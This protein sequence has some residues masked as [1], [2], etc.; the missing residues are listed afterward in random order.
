MNKVL[1]VVTH[2]G[3]FL[4]GEKTGLYL[5]ELIDVVRALEAVDCPFVFSTTT[6]GVPPIDGFDPDDE[7]HKKFFVDHGGELQKAVVLAEIDSTNFTAV[8]LIGGHGALYDFLGNPDITKTV[9]AIYAAGGLI[10]AT[11]H[12]VAGLVEASDGERL[13][14]EGKNVTTF[15]TMEEG[16]IDVAP[17]LPYSLTNILETIGAKTSYSAQAFES[18]VVVDGRV[19]TAQ[20]PQSVSKMMS[21]FLKLY[22]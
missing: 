20:N 13:L 21:E 17:F 14:L 3:E 18:N 5:P 6:G 11:T 22:S 8:I 19:L 12:G 4:L 15:S 1:I 2:V 10:A 9:N 16:F 7:T